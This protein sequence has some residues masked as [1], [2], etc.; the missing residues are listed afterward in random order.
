M[1]IETKCIYYALL[2]KIDID[3]IKIHKSGKHYFKRYFLKANF[4]DGFSYI[5]HISV[6]RG[7]Q[8]IQMK[9]D[10]FS[11]TLNVP[12][13]PNFIDKIRLLFKKHY[14]K[15]SKYKK[16]HVYMDVSMLT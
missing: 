10:I 6:Q 14:F 8:R 3:G 7:P 1:R 5:S 11:I 13:I 12:Y 15:V 4:F 16:E 2:N 9:N